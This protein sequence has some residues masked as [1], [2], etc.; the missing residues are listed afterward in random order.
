MKLSP[1]WIREFV[2]LKVDDHRLADDLTSIGIA[3]EGIAGN[4]E[5]TVFEMEIGTNRPDAMNHYGVAR[6]ASA[7]YDV[8][9]K[10][11]QPVLPMAKNSQPFP[12]EIQE[13]DLCPRFTV[14]A[15]RGVAIKPSPAKVVERLGLLDQRAINNAVD[16]TNY[17]L[18][19][20]GKPTHVFDLDLLEGG[21]IVVR[22]ARDGEVLKT[23]DGVERKLTSE[24]L[25][26]A[27]AVKPVG[28]AGVM[29][30]YDTMITDKTKNVLIESAWW[31]PVTV[32]KM[33]KR[34]GIHTDASH[35]FERGA[36]YESTVVSTNRVAEL[37]LAS[38]G[39]E[40]HGE[41]VDA[42]AKH[43]DQAPVMLQLSEVHRILG[44]QITVDE[45]LRVLHRLGF[46]TSLEGI[47][48]SE[49]AVRIPSWRLDV[50]REID[51][52]EEIAR[53]YG[54]DKFPNSLPAFAGSVIELPG[55]AK[56]QKL[57]SALLA[58]GYNEA[59]S[60]TFIAEKDA[61]GFSAAPTLELANPLSEEASVMRTSLVPS[62]L[63]MLAWNLNRATDNVRL[64][65]AGHVYEA[66]EEGSTEPKRI[67]I[68]ATGS[69][70]VP[71][72]N[73]PAR[74][75]NFF[76]LKGDL[77]TLLDLFDHGSLH[78]DQQTPSYY[79][80]G[81]SA[82]F[83][84]DGAVVA[85][86]GKVSQAAASGR[87]LRQDVFVAEIF[88]DTLYRHELRAI[89]FEALPRYPA[90]ERDFSFLFP[91]GVTFEAILVAVEALGLQE[92]RSF[93]PVEIFR[94]GK[95][96]AGKY[97][98][99]LRAKFQS[100]ERTL[101]EDEVAQWSAQIIKALEDLGGTLRV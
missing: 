86:F 81:Y 32:R 94:G 28:L 34:H 65:E 10:P 64:F 83:V 8:P 4:G 56:D 78:C 35:R 90:V 42:V 33:S 23:L 9:L 6:E 21:K 5:K 36:D 38:G 44:T 46:D 101:R 22:R 17:V 97:S 99:L 77:E 60:L 96:A 73:Q 67:C 19:E 93:Y 62:M 12:I 61:L 88:L 100:R 80:A 66:V 14:R 58:L 50:E 54:Y 20:I 75:L 30:G 51:L 95:V 63:D 87:K 76:D 68:G 72:V 49:F 43:M 24:D 27:D 45:M 59:V 16:A 7:F 82:R 52:I 89:R 47:D 1:Q 11:V 91:T 57:R 13:P 48:T 15:I 92:L 3:V 41:V 37:I 53:L 26:V 74:G 18:W 70:V 79:Q 39:G 25:V 2:D 40:L 69:A 29:G 71:S 85:Q 31:D 55:A 84:M 98:I